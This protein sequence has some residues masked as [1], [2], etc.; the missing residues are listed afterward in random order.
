[1]TEKEKK[2]LDKINIIT[3]GNSIV[4]KTSF[5]VR[6]AENVFRP[7]YLATI[8]IDFRAKTV[9]LPNKKVYKVYFYDTAGQEKYKSISLNSIKNTNGVL[10]MYDVTNRKSFESISGWMQSIL[11]EKG[12]DF[13]WK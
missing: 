11:S 1:M 5:I 3:L 4:G 9:E 10:L 8:G 6:F 7:D 2:N 13:N 12:K